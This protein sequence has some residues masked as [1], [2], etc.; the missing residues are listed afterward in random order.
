MQAVISHSLIQRLA[1]S[2]KPYE[3]RD[4]RLKGLLL[5]VQ[6]SG[7][8]TFYVEYARGRRVSVGRAEALAPTVARKRAKQILSDA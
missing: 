7:V 1:P 6:P 8:M 4:T 5:R 3:V 2:D